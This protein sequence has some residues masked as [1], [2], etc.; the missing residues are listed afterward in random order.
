MAARGHGW[1]WGAGA[2]GGLGPRGAGRTGAKGG[3]ESWVGRNRAE[4]AGQQHVLRPLVWGVGGGQTLEGACAPPCDRGLGKRGRAT[5]GGGVIAQRAA[6]AHTAGPG[7]RAKQ[8]P[9]GLGP[10]T[11]GPH[12]LGAGPVRRVLAGS[13]DRTAAGPGPLPRGETARLARDHTAAAVAGAAV[14][15]GDTGVWGVW[16]RSVTDL[17]RRP[18]AT[19]QGSKGPGR[20]G[21]GHGKS[22]G[23]CWELQC[24]PP[25]EICWGP[26]PIS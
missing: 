25:K 22:P 10:P 26:D 6:F 4:V 15:P 7:S 16:T 19:G 20:G 13:P 8:T 14:S 11:E 3:L 18:W 2:A 17:G 21:G 24:G 23:G 12:F 1:R 9:L 5:L